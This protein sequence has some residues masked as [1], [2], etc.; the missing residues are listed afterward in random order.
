MAIILPDKPIGPRRIDPKILILYGA[1]KVGK[2]E[3]LTQLPGCLILDGEEGT[4]MHNNVI[5][6]DFRSMKDIKEIKDAIYTKGVE[7]AK[8]GKVGLDRFPYRYI[9]IDTLDSAED[10]IEPTLTSRYKKTTKGKDFDGTS[11]LELDYG[12]GYYFLREGIKEVIDDI[13][14]VCP[15][16]IL[17]SHLKEKIINKGGIDVVSQDISLTGKLGS[18]VAAMADAIGYVYRKGTT[19]GEPDKTMINFRSSDGI[20]MGA[21][22]KHLAGQTFEFDWSRIYTEDLALK[23]EV[24]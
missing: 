24:V 9:A 1:K 17:I 20:T 4:Y 11:I 8:A 2:T 3:L 16:L 7:R 15:H 10:A 12:G 13:G 18:I 22:A 14:G 19:P 5:S 21:R 6:V 23:K